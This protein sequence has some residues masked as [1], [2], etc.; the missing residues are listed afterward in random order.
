M[1]IRP[2]VIDDMPQLTA[3]VEQYWLFEGIEGFSRARIE[4]CLWRLLSKPGLGAAWVAADGPKLHGYLVAMLVFSLEHGGLMAEVDEFFVLPERRSQGT[5]K[6][7]LAAAERD[8]AAQ[9]CV[10]L[11]LQLG[12][13]NELARDFYHRHGYRERRGFELLD[14]PL[15]VG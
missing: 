6:Q 12:S 1:I 10:R 11:Q 3:L 2:A 14:K 5:G 9:G 15:K 8:L 13:G 4:D 7:L